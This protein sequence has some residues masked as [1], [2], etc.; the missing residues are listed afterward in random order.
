[1]KRVLLGV[2]GSI[3][4]YKAADIVRLL[5]KE[6]I[7]VQVVQTPDSLRFVSPVTFEALSGHKVIV[8]PWEDVDHSRVEHI[9][10]GREFD[11]LLIAPASLDL[12]G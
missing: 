3:S 10:L 5:K 11:L 4:A 9:A 8:D 1:M 2:T 12:I 7:D 6:G